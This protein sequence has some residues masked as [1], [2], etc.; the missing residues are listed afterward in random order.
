MKALFR[1]AIAFVFVMIAVPALAD[2]GVCLAMVTDAAHNI[3]LS[4]SSQSYMNVI[5]DNYCQQ[6]GT[7]KSSSFNGSLNVVVQEIPIGLTGGATNSQTAMSNFCRNY[8]STF[9]A[10]SSNFGFQSLVVQNA[11]QSANDCLKIVTSGAA[12]V[13]NILSPTTLA[14][15]FTVPSGQTMNIRGVSHESTVTCLGSNVSGGQAINYSTGTGQTLTGAAGS[16]SITCTRTPFGVSAGTQ[17][18]NATALVVDTNTGGLNIF[19]PQESVL[20]LTTASQIQSS[21]SG[22][23]TQIR[24]TQATVAL[25]ALPPGSIIPWFGKGQAIPAGWVP[26]DGSTV[27]CPDLR[28][29]FLRGSDQNSIGQPGGSDSTS[30]SY[31]VGDPN[32]NGYNSGGTNRAIVFQPSAIP[33]VPKYVSVLYIMK[34]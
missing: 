11:L 19:W 2:D 4:T 12:I 8:Q 29:L 22:L 27:A 28:S 5:F 7:T 32:G 21:V 17:F 14:I 24:Q 10:S 15:R 33:T 1:A 6:D 9:S 3:G 16:Y 13:Y 30:L 31:T 23:A 25:N 34:Q 26:C 20:P 18:Y